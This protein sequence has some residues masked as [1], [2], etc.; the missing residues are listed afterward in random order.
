MKFNDGN[1]H[2]LPFDN[3]EWFNHND[4]ANRYRKKHERRLLRHPTSHVDNSRS[5][6]TCKQKQ[7]E[8]GVDAVGDQDDNGADDD[9]DPVVGTIFLHQHINSHV[10]PS[11]YL[12]KIQSQQDLQCGFCLE[13]RRTEQLP[14]TYNIF[15][16]MSFN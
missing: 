15:D 13:P 12:Q 16:S 4:H 9:G 11:I 2:G 6:R 5:Y 3:Q 14:Q 1:Q 10:L 7:G 8:R